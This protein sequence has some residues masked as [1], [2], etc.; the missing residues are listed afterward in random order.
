VRGAAAART[1]AHGTV[2][3]VERIGPYELVQRLGVGGMG[4]VWEAVLVGPAGFRKPVAL[5]CLRPD[6]VARE[7]FLDALLREAR[8][9]GRLQHPNV[10]GTLGLSEHGGSWVIALELVRGATVGELVQAVGPLPPRV[11]LDL[12]VQTCAG[13][14]HAHE[15]GLVHRDV[16]PGNLLVDRWGVVKLADLGISITTGE[17]GSKGAGTPGYAAP[18]QLDG[19]AVPRS[20][21]FSLGVVLAACATGR[22]LFARG[23]T[24][25]D[26]V[27]RVEELLGSDGFLDDV[28]RAVPGLGEVVRRCLRA[29]PE[30]RWPDARSLAAALDGL[31]RRQA[32]GGPTLVALLGR[33]RPA[34]AIEAGTPS[35]GSDEPTRVLVNGNLPPPRDRFV[36]RTDLAAEVSDR[37][38]RGARLLTLLGTGGMGKTRLALEVARRAGPSVPGGA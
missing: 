13:L 16:K 17:G 15:S 32:E 30:L 8:L 29:E 18:E 1:L 25:I 23:P 34:L 2:R 36:G 26:E 22:R 31:R 35:V 28:G 12:G 7:G 37:V 21:L 27:R 10:V 11:V 5:K 33:A 9:G 38:L 3:G 24:G 14:A 19:A 4:E 20:D 6:L